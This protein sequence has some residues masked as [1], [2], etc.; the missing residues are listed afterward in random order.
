[1]TTKMAIRTVVSVFAI[2]F[3]LLVPGAAF[4]GGD[5]EEAVEAAAITGEFDWRRF[6]GETISLLGVAGPYNQEIT[7]AVGPFE[8]LTGISVTLDFLPESD[9][10]NKVQLV[11][12]AGQGEY[13]LYM[14]GFPNMIDWV[15]A[16]WLEPLDDYLANESIT[17]PDIDMADFYPAILDNVTWDG[18]NG[19]AFG[20]R[21][22]A[23]QWAMPLGVM[24]NMLMYRADVF[25]ELGLEVPVTVRDAI[26]VSRVIQANT[27]L[28]GISTRGVKEI[29]QIFG[30]V[31][32]TL[33]SYGATDFD[34]NLEPQFASPDMHRALQEWAELIN[35]G[36]NINNWAG[37]TWYDV[38]TDVQFGNSAMMLDASSI[39]GWIN[40]GED[41][42]AK[43]VLAFA[44]PLVEDD[45]DE[46]SSFMWAWNIALSSA[47]RNKGP[48]WYFAQFVTGKEMQREGTVMSWPTRSSVFE[49]PDFRAANAA[50]RGFF[51]A[52][53][54][55]IPYAGF[56]LT[57]AIGFNDYGYELAGEIQNV[58]LGEKTAEQAMADLVEYYEDNFR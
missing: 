28:Y 5:Q 25:E 47:G 13:D 57:P 34:E 35:V 52:W 48:A 3:A 2:L 40:L 23:S 51:E 1:M 20:P 44:P 10:F 50:N 37:M 31:W 6:E 45:T 24:I 27:D 38:Q 29:Q 33:Q 14:V 22:G 15:P 7:E 9:Y 54:A 26:E 4:A 21:E 53:E 18:E 56:V 42:P 11:A 30:G 16:G 41:S 8:A 58:V 46:M 32:S 12:A 17:N 19:H 43:G 49:D 39:G 36:G 55:T